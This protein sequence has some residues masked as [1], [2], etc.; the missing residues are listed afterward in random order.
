M[1][2]NS[3]VRSSTCLH[4]LQVS[5]VFAVSSSSPPASVVTCSLIEDPSREGASWSAASSKPDADAGF[6]QWPGEAEVWLYRRI[7]KISSGK[8]YS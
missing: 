3:L 7:S 6:P 8:T 2:M 1:L 5:P 4:R